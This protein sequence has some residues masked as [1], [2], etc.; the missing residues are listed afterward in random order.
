VSR[1]SLDGDELGTAKKPFKRQREIFFDRPKLPGKARANRALR[2]KSYAGHRRSGA[3]RD[4]TVQP[5]FGMASEE[6]GLLA[7]RSRVRR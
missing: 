4:R 2:G 3:A 1:L 5:F 7:T 6:R